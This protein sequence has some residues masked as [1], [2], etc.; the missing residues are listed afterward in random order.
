MEKVTT[1]M[2]NFYNEKVIL[3]SEKVQDIRDKK[4]K[5]IDRLKDG[6]K[7]YNE[8]NEKSY[9]LY[10]SVE[11]GS[12]AMSTAINPEY[13]DFDIDVAIIFEKSNIPNNT[14]DVKD[15]IIE[16]LKPYNYLFKKNPTKKKNCIRIE[17]QDDYHIDFAIYRTENEYYE[18]CGES[19]TE[20]NPRSIT[21]WFYEKNHLYDNKLRKITRLIKYFAKTRKEW[22][23]CGG[24]IITVLVE[25]Q[26]SNID[27]NIS[28]DK[29]LLDVINKLIDRINYNKSVCNPVND[30]E[31]ITS[32]EHKEKLNN[33]SEK[34]NMFVEKLN[35]AYKN[36]NIDEIYNAWNSF[37][38]TDYFNNE[39]K[40]TRNVCEDNEMFIGNLYPFAICPVKLELKCQRYVS[41]DNFNKSTQIN[42]FDDQPFSLIQNKDEQICFTI[43][44][45]ISKP[46]TVLWK[47]KN[48]GSKAIEKNMLRGDLHY[49]NHLHSYEDDI[50]SDRRF[51]KINFEGNHYVECYLIKDNECVA[52]K[53]FNVKII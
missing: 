39:S 33:L 6:I 27:I 20:R 16:F 50:N 8:K 43:E 46:Y 5:N 3:P 15:L 22:N 32:D 7:Q 40:E 10:D 42:C 45:N 24:L 41:K 2:N 9:K 26:L 30:Q 28:L 47:V 25:E 14:D 1:R 36:E 51:E 18:H 38:K 52:V 21:N 37:F 4:R 19:W 44:T 12:I 48:N 34:L 11:Q 13:D 49:G 29:L 53:R 35:T 31:L 23:I 17:Y